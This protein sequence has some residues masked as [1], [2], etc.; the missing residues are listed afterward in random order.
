MIR[1]LLIIG[2]LAYGVAAANAQARIE[3]EYK[4]AVPEHQVEP[5]WQFLKANFSGNQSGLF[6]DS[7]FNE[8]ATEIFYD[9][10]F[11]DA[12]K[13]LL[14]FKAGV[15]HRQRFVND[16]LVKTLV[17]LKVPTLDEKGIAREEHKF[18]VKE[19]Q[20]LSDRSGMHPFLQY[21][22]TKDRSDVNLVL[23]QF[24]IQARSLS[25][26]LKVKQIRRRIYISDALG[27]LM[28]LTLDE[29]SS[30]YFPY[31]SFVE[32]ELELN[33]IRFTQAEQEEKFRL[34]TLNANSKALIFDNF[35]DLQ[36]DQTPKYNKMHNRLA[37]NK[38]AIV[39]NNLMYVVLGA[40]CLFAIFLTMNNKRKIVNT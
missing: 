2:L 36:Q 24:G 28:T 39:Y 32:L 14:G 8:Q 10:Y 21:I 18:N 15:R 7:V 20:Q 12:A 19:D 6:R 3:S 1:V 22:K 5:L 23:G 38:L 25:Q 35:K 4:I 13:T 9:T 26:S 11:D 34:E 40:I 33:E 16:S 17:Q 31:D 37:K 27:P 30:F 29:V